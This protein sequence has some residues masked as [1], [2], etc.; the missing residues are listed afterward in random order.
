MET[1]T[2]HTETTTDLAEGTSE[3][4][5]DVTIETEGDEKSESAVDRMLPIME[6]IDTRLRTL[7]ERFWAMPPPET[8]APVVVAPPPAAAPT[9]PPAVAEPAPAPA[10]A[11]SEVPPAPSPE[12]AKAEEPKETKIETPA[13]VNPPKPKKRR[14]GIFW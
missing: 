6:R 14:P 12:P 10:P 4:V 3:T 1:E 5:E 8:P 11:T 13:H 9:A 7:E 2:R